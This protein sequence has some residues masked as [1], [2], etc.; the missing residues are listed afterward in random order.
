LPAK[1][2]EPNPPIYFIRHGETDWNREQRI[3]G[4]TDVPLN[5]Q[6]HLQAEAVA[7]A[8]KDYLRGDK[9]DRFIVSPLTRARQSMD[10]VARQF[11]L[12]PS[13]IDI[14][15]VMTELGF[16][17]WE[18]RT[19]SELHADPECP[20]TPLERFH[21]RP[22]GGESYVD[23]L[24]RIRQWIGRFSGPTVIVAHGAIGRCLIGLVADLSPEQLVQAKTPQGSF[25][26]LQNG[27]FGWVEAGDWSP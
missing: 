9:I 3:Q 21:W 6:G 25:C 16:G 7:R 11:D 23:G 1:V 12:P 26:R 17:V 24:A 4:L 18:G 22:R 8:L 13:L 20:K 15:P 2:I 19:V 14:D 27:Q 10:Y 5:G